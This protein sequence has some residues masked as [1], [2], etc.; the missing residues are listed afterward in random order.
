MWKVNTTM[1][2][3]P[4]VVQLLLLAFKST[5]VI[6][7]GWWIILLP[8]EILLLTIAVCSICMIILAII[9]TYYGYQN[10]R[11]HSGSF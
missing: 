4:I 11:D 8:I 9:F 1:V 2:K 6:D 5:G 3:A 7:W 10:K